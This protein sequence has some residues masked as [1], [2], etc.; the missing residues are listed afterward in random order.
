MGNLRSKITPA[1]KAQ[2]HKDGYFI[3]HNAIPGEHLEL[4]RRVCA[5]GTAA[6][7]ARMEREGTKV[8]GINHKGKRYFI[9]QSY[10]DYAALGEFLLSPLMAEI[11]RSTVG[12]VAYLH[13]DQFV[14]KMEKAGMKFAWHQDGAYVHAR[15]GDHPECITC[16]CALDDV[17]AT[18]GTV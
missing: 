7:D 12:D 18:N 14:V 8:L 5:D 3:V 4:L 13:N 16:W 2:Y 11:C 6:M 15:V 10:R 1:A 9:G 17:D